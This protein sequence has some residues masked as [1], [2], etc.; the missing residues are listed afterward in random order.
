MSEAPL[1]TFGWSIKS[2][3]ELTY[4]VNFIHDFIFSKSSPQAFLACES[5][6]KPHLSAALIPCSKL[7]SFPIL[8][9]IKFPSLSIDTCPDINNNFPII[10]VA[11]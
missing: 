7:K 1:I 11:V 4:P 3:V 10:F 5:K 8:P 2:F 9:L 6:L